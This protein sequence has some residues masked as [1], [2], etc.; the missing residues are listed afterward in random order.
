MGYLIKIRLFVI[1][2]V[3]VL[4]ISCSHEQDKKEAPSFTSFPG[5][6]SVLKV[7]TSKIKLFYEAVGTIKARTSTIL[8]SKVQGHVK[9]INVRE[10]DKV[11]AGN[12]LIII[13]DRGI[14]AK[15]GQARAIHESALNSLNEITTGIRQA[16]TNKKQS[17]AQ[18]DLARST[19]KRFEKL[20]KELAISKQELDTVRAKLRV[21]EEEVN[22]ATQ[23][24]EQLLSR[25]KQVHA[26]IEQ[27]KSGVEEAG[28]MMSHTKILAPFDGV[29]IK[30]YLGVGGLASPGLPLLSLENPEGFHLEVNVNEE[31]A[32]DVRPGREVDVII[33]AVGEKKIKGT[34]STI[35]PS[36]NALSRTFKV[37][38]AL[39]YVETLK[40]GMY[41]KAMC[42]IGEKDGI[43]IPGKALIRRGQLE[44]VFT[45]GKDSFVRMRLVKV[46]KIFGNNLEI[47]TGLRQ[48]DT[49]IV[50]V[51]NGL[52][53]GYKVEIAE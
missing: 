44:Q 49:I 9:K 4:A 50:D 15:L 25:K 28:V 20:F 42:S 12:L 26:S 23:R 53:D 33:D 45:V 48:G 8:S 22:A 14:K 30:K 6:V 10:G 5:K 47:L 37:K 27:A 36:A 43:L 46:G 51:P 21:A 3:I 2:F 52:K 31:F 7:E 13:D 41:G 24:I 11:K 40:T 18:L 32:K 19:S 29:I 17:E 39:P 38:I 35:I 1:S 34:V 16:R